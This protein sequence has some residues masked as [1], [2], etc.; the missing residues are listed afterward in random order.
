M[1]LERVCRHLGYPKTIRVDQVSEFVSL[2]LDLWAYARGVTLDFSRPSKPT[3]TD[4][5]EKVSQGDHEEL[6]TDLIVR[7]AGRVRHADVKLAYSA[8]A[9][10]LRR[11]SATRFSGM[12]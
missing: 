2:D 10:S 4:V 6:S 11:R 8:S 5:I 1:T 3:D 12:L 9:T 7:D